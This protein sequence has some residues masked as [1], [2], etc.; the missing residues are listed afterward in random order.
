[1]SKTKAFSC[2][3]EMDLVHHRLAEQ[4]ARISVDEE[5]ERL[6]AELGLFEKNDTRKS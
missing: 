2:Q 4:I 6:K 3:E 5:E 1:M